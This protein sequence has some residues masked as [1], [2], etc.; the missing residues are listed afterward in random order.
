MELLEP[1]L[2]AGC[3]Y[4]RSKGL[5]AWSVNLISLRGIVRLYQ[6]VD[7][8]RQEGIEGHEHKLTGLLVKFPVEGVLGIV[9]S[10][11]GH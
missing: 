1:N 9:W 3:E 4:G 5:M 7:T 11:P 2:P 8:I 6:T 10:I